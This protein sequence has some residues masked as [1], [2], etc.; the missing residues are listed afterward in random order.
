MKLFALKDIFERET[1]MNHGIT[2]SRILELLD[3]QGIKAER[4][5]IYDDIRAFQDYGIDI[6][7]AQG[8]N[9]EYSLASRTFDIDE[10]KVMVDAIQL[11]SSCLKQRP[12]KSSRSW[13]PFA[14]SM[15][16]KP[17]SVRS[18]WQTESRA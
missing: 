5:S 18:L 15:K 13:R 16:R 17:F 14:A 10:I 2:M 7:P 3:M 12:E 9:R 1:D 6:T 4:K 8:Q 11:P